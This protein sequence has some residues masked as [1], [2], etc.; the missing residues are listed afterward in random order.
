MGGGDPGGVLD[1]W[2][3]DG[4]E[5]AGL[6]CW[7]R[8]SRGAD[9]QETLGKTCVDVHRAVVGENDGMASELDFGTAVFGVGDFAVV[10]QFFESLAKTG[11]IP[12]ASF[13]LGGK[14]VGLR[15]IFQGICD[16]P[17]RVLTH[18]A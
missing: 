15:S 2:T 5:N 17:E 18:L 8:V 6:V 11:Q 4:R 1:L 3:F 10:A 14:L 12:F 16:G 13:I 9:L 7:G